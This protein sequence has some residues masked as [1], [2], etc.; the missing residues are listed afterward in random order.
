ML[1]PL[2]LLYHITGDPRLQ[3][4]M[5]DPHLRAV[6]GENDRQGRSESQTGGDLL[7]RSSLVKRQR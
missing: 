1:V 6:I 2:G 7:S 3:A 4:W 5:T